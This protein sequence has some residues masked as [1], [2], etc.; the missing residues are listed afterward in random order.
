[1]SFLP[2]YVIYKKSTVPFLYC[3]LCQRVLE[4]AGANSH[5]CVTSIAEI[6]TIFTD[7]PQRVTILEERLNVIYPY[8]FPLTLDGKITDYAYCRKCNTFLPKSVAV[9]VRRPERWDRFQIHS[10]I[11]SIFL[12]R[13][14]PSLSPHRGQ[15]EHCRVFPV[16]KSEAIAEGWQEG[17]P[18]LRVLNLR[19]RAEFALR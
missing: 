14:Q 11:F 7:E 19:W 13:L 16:C 4:E 3:R 5:E 2:R 15:Q 17:C 9:K 18:V 1:M 10:R 8:I 6:T 12:A